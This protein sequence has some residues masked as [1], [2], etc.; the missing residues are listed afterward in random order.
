M[1]RHT[2]PLVAEGWSCPEYDEF[3]DQ[4]ATLHEIH[5][6]PVRGVFS[7]LG[8]AFD[9]DDAKLFAA[10]PELL[11]AL[12]DLLAFVYSRIDAEEFE[13]PRYVGII[14]KAK[15]EQP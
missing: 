1:P 6:P 8:Y 13:Y 7:T 14:A 2:D 10:A 3:G 9:E 11:A 4:I 12:E 15:G 5:T